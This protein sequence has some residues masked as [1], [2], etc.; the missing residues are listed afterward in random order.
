MLPPE[1]LERHREIAREGWDLND[2]VVLVPSGMP[3][4]IDGTDG[5]HEFHAHAE[6][7]WLAGTD[8]PGQVLAYDPEEG[9]VLFAHV[10]SPD[11][12]VW[13]GA[14]E[15]LDAIRARTGLGK[16][17]A[18]EELGAW[19]SRRITAPVAILGNRDILRHAE[20]YGAAG[21]GGPGFRVDEELSNRLSAVITD[22][23]R[24]KDDGEIALM[25]L[26]ADATAA[27]HVAGMRFARAGVTERMLKVEIES[28][29]FR[30]GGARTAYPSIVGSGENAATLH[31]APGDRALADGDLVLV[32]AGAEVGGYMSDVTRTFPAGGAFTAEQADLYDLLLGVQKHAVAKVRPGKEYREI[33]LE[34]CVEIARGL[35]DHGILRGDPDSLVERDAHALFFPH[36]IGHMIGLATHDVGGY[37]EGRKPSDRFGLKWL[38]TDLALEAGHVVTIEPGIYFIRALLTDPDRRARHADDV[39]W[40]KVDG[41]LDFGGYRIEDDV[42]A[43]ADGPVVLTD[44]TPKERAEVEALAAEGAR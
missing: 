15:D 27:G 7:Y 31:Y 29:F 6:H 11:E 14:G 22:A 21:L 44:G 26:A 42:L 8:A 19:L 34:A 17:L 38:R 20:R 3:V 43:T 23:R 2:G 41:M 9:F 39:N 5:Y 33:H 10:A 32:D 16:V 13:E 1:S 28:A 24:R 25:R 18:R 36:G 12:R 35:V 4:G 30:A 37:A 40:E